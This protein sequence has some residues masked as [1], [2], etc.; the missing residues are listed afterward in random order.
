MGGNTSSSMRSKLREESKRP[1]VIS[2]G[3]WGLEYL[4]SRRSATIETRE[5]TA[6]R[7]RAAV[8]LLAH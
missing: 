1:C 6:M 5:T 8:I 3:E 7:D 2:R 4:T